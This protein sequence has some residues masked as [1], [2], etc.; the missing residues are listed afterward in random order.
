ME[1]VCRTPS[2]YR[3]FIVEYSDSVRAA[4]DIRA[5]VSNGRRSAAPNFNRNCLLTKH[6]SPNPKT[7][8]PYLLQN[9]R[10]VVPHAQLF[11]MLR[12]GVRAASPRAFLPR[13]RARIAATANRLA[14][15][16]ASSTSSASSSRIGVIAGITAVV[17]YYG[18]IISTRDRLY[19]EDQARGAWYSR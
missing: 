1:L 13:S 5:N 4:D 12:T 6:I 17:G 14:H 15:T 2:V 9:H 11:I 10:C 3:E 18:L 19:M 7:W 16:Y 8:E